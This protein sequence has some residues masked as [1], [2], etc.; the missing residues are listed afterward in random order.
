MSNQDVILLANNHLPQF[1]Q[2]FQSSP[3]YRIDTDQTFTLNSTPYDASLN[4]FDH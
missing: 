1:S 3:I 2:L 4:L